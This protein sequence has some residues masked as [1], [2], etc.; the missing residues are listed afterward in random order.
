[1]GTGLGA[2]VRVRGRRHRRCGEPPRPGARTCSSTRARAAAARRPTGSTTTRNGKIDDFRGW[3]FVNNDNNPT[4]DNEHGTHVAGTI[5]GRANNAL[6]V[7]GCGELPQAVGH[8]RGP[9]IVPIK[10]LNAAGSGSFAGIADGIVYAGTMG[11]KVANVEPRRRR[12][13]RDARQRDQGQAEHALRGRRR[14]RRRRQRHRAARVP[15]SRPRL[16]DAANKIC[17]AATDSQRPAR[18][19]LELRRRRTST[20]RLP[21]CRS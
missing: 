3:D 11:A 14:Q 17:V 6:G 20:W 12:H 7:A 16:P 2:S 21:A 9:K 4:D 5:A 10:V 1:M 8:W 18:R 13:V 19:L 15:A